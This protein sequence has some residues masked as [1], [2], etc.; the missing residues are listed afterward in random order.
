MR[1]CCVRCETERS[2]DAVV[3]P[4]CGGRLHALFGNM[5]PKMLSL[6]AKLMPA[7]VVAI[8]C[9]DPVTRATVRAEI[10]G[11]RRQMDEQI[12]ANR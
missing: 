10:A 5:T 7:T 6:Y 12:Y 11:L 9:K 2:K 1:M 3:C 4:E 8:A